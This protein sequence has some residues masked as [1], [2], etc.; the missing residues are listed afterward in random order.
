MMNIFV[1]KIIDYRSGIAR[2]F[3]ISDN[4][5]EMINHYKNYVR[6]TKYL[7]TL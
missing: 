5:T 1:L 6:N 7:M 2:L 4:A 3:V